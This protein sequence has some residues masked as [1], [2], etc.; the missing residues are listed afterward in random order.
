M[1]PL[2]NETL[3]CHWLDFI[4]YLVP[5]L[6]YIQNLISYHHLLTTWFQ[7]TIILLWIYRN[8]P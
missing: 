7:V 4:N 6:D 5:F 8:S 3:E 1:R 2:K